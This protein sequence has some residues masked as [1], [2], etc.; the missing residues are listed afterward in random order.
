MPPDSSEFP[1]VNHADEF[2]L[3]AVGSNLHPKT[4]QKA[5]RKGIFPWYSEDEPICWYSPAQRCVLFAKDIKVSKSMKQVLKQNKFRITMDNCFEEVIRYC[6]K[7]D[8]K[9][10]DGTWIVDD[11]QEAYIKLHRMG[12]A[13]SIEV[14]HDENLV[15]GLYGI[16]ISSKLFSGESMFSLMPNASKAALIWLCQNQDFELIDCQVESA[17]LLSMGAKVISRNNYLQLLNRLS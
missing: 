10:Q 7:V 6:A 12:M 9:G 15:G 14:W 16:A 11:M 4:L 13:H 3:L 1:S 8:R 5:F 17:H 2:G